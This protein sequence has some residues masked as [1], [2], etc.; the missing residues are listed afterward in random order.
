MVFIPIRLNS[1]TPY[2]A[3]FC[4]LVLFSCNWNKDTLE[5]KDS[6]VTATPPTVPVDLSYYNDKLPDIA[7]A[8]PYG[9]SFS[10]RR[11]KAKFILVEF[12]ASWCPPCRGANPGLVS[13]YN[14]YHN[15]GFEIVSISLDTDANTWKKAIE[16]DHLDW[17]YH[18]TDLKGWDSK[19]AA[20]Y[21]IEEIPNNVLYSSDGNILGQAFEPHS[22]DK[23]LGELLSK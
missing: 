23:V 13:V 18:L 15:Q 16:S 19:W 14:K 9:D 20:A 7:G 2:I 3:L 21:K 17:P 1:N 22:L 11:I 4:A 6:I 12:W 8:N 10:I 5:H